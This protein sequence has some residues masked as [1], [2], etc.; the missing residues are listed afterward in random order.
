MSG[1]EQYE[2]VEAIQTMIRLLDKYHADKL[3]D[4]LLEYK[5][6]EK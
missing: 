3:H 4:F 5:P 6:E 1:V 2:I